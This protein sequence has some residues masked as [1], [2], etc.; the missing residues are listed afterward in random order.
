MTIEDLF[1]F[2]LLILIVAFAV[3]RV[4]GILMTYPHSLNPVKAYRERR[5]VV[6]SARKNHPSIFGNSE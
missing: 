5:G 6:E 1:S 3:V 2:V 4:R